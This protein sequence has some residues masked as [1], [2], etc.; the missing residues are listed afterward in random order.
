VPGIQ[1]V[2]DYGEEYFVIEGAFYDYLEEVDGHMLNT[3]GS[4][5][6][7]RPHES[8]HG[9]TLTIQMHTRLIFR[10]DYS[11]SKEPMGIEAAVA[12][13][14]EKGTATGADGDVRPVLPVAFVE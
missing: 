4:Y 13:S 6:C 14:K 7:R 5:G 8:S 9:D 3:A 12:K 2:H 11:T 1:Q 10:G